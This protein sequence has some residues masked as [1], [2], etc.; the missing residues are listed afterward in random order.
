MLLLNF[1]SLKKLD[2]PDQP[3]CEATWERPLIQTAYFLLHLIRQTLQKRSTKQYVFTETQNQ[4]SG[5]VI[6][7]LSS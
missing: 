5:L 6:A 1:K 7:K 4:E 2:L 3:D